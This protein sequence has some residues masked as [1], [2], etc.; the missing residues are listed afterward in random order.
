MA[1]IITLFEV[2]KHIFNPAGVKHPR[3]A[4]WAIFT[5]S[6]AVV[7]IASVS[8]LIQE[9]CKL[10]GNSSTY[11]QRCIFGTSIGSMSLALGGLAL[12]CAVLRQYSTNMLRAELML[13][14]FITIAWIFGVWLIT[15]QQG[16]G[17]KCAALVD[18]SNYL[19]VCK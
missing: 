1:V 19:I 5:F 9:K 11:C 15:G 3:L 8:S 16:P 7:L 17:K 18:S 4:P 10:I 6:S 14:F 2:T 13:S 12:A